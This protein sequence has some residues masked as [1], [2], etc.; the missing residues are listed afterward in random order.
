M[1]QVTDCVGLR[2]WQKP[3]FGLRIICKLFKNLLPWYIL[4][5]HLIILL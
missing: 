3:D 2:Q 4:I 5:I 1:S